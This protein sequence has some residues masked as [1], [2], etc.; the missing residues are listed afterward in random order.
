MPGNMIV[1]LDTKL[2]FIYCLVCRKT[3]I[4]YLPRNTETR[5]QGTSI[6][7]SVEIRL[8]ILVKSRSQKITTLNSTVS[9]SVALLR[10]R[11]LTPFHKD[12]MSELCNIF[13]SV[14]NL[15]AF[16]SGFTSIVRLQRLNQINHL[17]VILAQYFASRSSNYFVKILI[18][19]KFRCDA[20]IR[21]W[22]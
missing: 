10:V 7:R 2:F 19:A 11:L 3:K 9:I 20:D 18:C 12:N 4:S 14:S 22:G 5:Q 16:L 15:P 21:G 6:I 17:K 1:R 8:S 13:A